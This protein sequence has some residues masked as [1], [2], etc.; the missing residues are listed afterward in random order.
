M[1]NANQVKA[2]SAAPPVALRLL[3]DAADNYVT[4]AAP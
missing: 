4:V 1:P 3:T 2:M